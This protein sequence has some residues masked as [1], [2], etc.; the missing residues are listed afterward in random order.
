[1]SAQVN[2][3]DHQSLIAELRGFHTTQEL[4][5]SK[6]WETHQQYVS[7]LLSTPRLDEF[8]QAQPRL[9]KFLRIAHW[10]LEKGKH[11]DAAIAAFRSHLILQHADLIS[12]NEADAGMNRSQQR[13]VT[14]EIGTALGMHTAFAPV[15]LEFS[16]GYGDDLLMSGENTLALQGNAILSRY[17]L[18]N[19]RIIQLPLC[20]DHFEQ[21]EK[22]IG[23]RNALAA[24][25]DVNGHNLTFVT[26]HLEVR[27]SP[28][29]RA[30][31]MAAILNHLRQNG[32]NAPT[33]IAGDFNSNTF[34]RGGRWRTLSGF[35][36][37][38]LTKPET[39]MREIA[40][41]QSREPLFDVLAAHGFTDRGFN[42]ADVTCYV[43]LTI[44]EDR[45]HLP[46]VFADIMDRRLAPYAGRLDFRLDWMLGRNITALNE[47]EVAD[48]QSGASRLNPQTIAGLKNEMGGQISDHDPITVDVV[49][50]GEK[51]S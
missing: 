48:S 21:A 2:Y 46:K 3:Q 34:A 7:D 50:P 38:L 18:G 43:P 28:A 26:T 4:Q 45:S 29:C 10:N 8:P 40:A 44:L 17:P 25:V 32:R 27:N 31:Q 6:A 12:I 13:D 37:M 39:L 36:R 20:Y 49:L 5:S 1:M 11:L 47:G 22:R 33:I 15:Y 23:N 51:E 14:R 19:V 41:P 24:E 35:A 9:Q 30:R 16:K 42:S